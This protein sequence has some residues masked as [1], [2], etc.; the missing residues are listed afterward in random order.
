MGIVPLYFSKTE[1]IWTLQRQVSMLRTKKGHFVVTIYDQ[2]R[3][4]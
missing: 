4:L 3:G 2:D 1:S